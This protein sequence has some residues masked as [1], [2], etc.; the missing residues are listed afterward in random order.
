M[1]ENADSQQVADSGNEKE[2]GINFNNLPKD[3]SIGIIKVLGVGGGGCNAVRNMYLEGITNVTYAACNTDS[4]QLT[5]CPVPVK[6]QLGADGLGAGGNPD[7]GREEAEHTRD[8]IKAL[9]D[10]GT[11]MVFVTASMGGGTGTGAAP[12]VAQVAKEMGILTIGIVTIPFS[13]EGR[14]K[15]MKALRG[16]EE[17]RKYVDA[18][19]VIQNDK[20]TGGT[21][22]VLPDGGKQRIPMKDKFKDADNILKDAAKSI[23][24]LITLHTDGDI[25]LDF[26]DVETTMKN[27][28]DAI[29]AAG[30]ASG[31]HRVERA[32]IQALDSPLLYGNDIGRAQ[33]ILFDVY[34]SEEEPL[35]FDEMKEIEEFMK[36]LDPDIDVIWGTSTDNTL[37]KDA[38]VIILAA[39]MAHEMKVEKDGHD[40]AVKDDEYFHHIMQ[41]L[42]A[43]PKVPVRTVIEPQLE[44]DDIPEQEEKGTPSSEMTDGV[45]EEVADGEPETDEQPAKEPM[46]LKSFLDKAKDWLMKLTED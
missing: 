45:T 1:A 35:Y 36:Q 46:R 10:D 20:L 24:E 4:Q 17:M 7:K 14:Q 44:F 21:V 26:R 40:T 41:Q 25:N 43:S 30:R 9:L 39:A 8:R 31:D 6:L 11:K 38:K 3:T 34:T 13:F 18:L 12:I 33:R 2:T 16:M 29:M 42:Y 32:I 37:G 28:G 5:R 22:K 15:I 19:L 23:S 27:G